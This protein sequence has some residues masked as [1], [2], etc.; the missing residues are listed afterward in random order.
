MRFP[1]FNQT[2]KCNLV[3]SR[4]NFNRFVEKF[5]AKIG[6]LVSFCVGIVVEHVACPFDH[7]KFQSEV[8]AERAVV[9]ASCF[10]V[11]FLNFAKFLVE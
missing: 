5:S 6:N 3:R 1:L 10:L 11:P 8:V 7:G 2:L 4:N 9:S